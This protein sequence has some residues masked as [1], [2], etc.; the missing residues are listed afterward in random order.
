MPSDT[1][2]RLPREK[3]DRLMA[4]AWDEFTKVPYIDA[5]INKIVIKAR[6]P[7]GSFYQYFTD[8]EDLFRYLL[9]GVRDHVIERTRT[10]LEKERADLFSFPVLMFD[11]LL[12][13]NVLRDDMVTA[14]MKVLTINPKLDLQELCYGGADL[15]S[16][17][18]SRTDQTVLRSQ[19]PLYVDQILELIIFALGRA[20]LGTLGQPETAPEQ[21][22]KLKTKVEIIRT[23]CCR[24][25]TGGQVC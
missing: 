15:M 2:F 18:L 14:A 23:G 22:H 7:R 19:E 17:I 21:R 12:R 10:T 6:I 3:Q 4:A 11:E 5:S 25:M 8:K 1:F 13:E 20:I 9:A 16:D 24:E